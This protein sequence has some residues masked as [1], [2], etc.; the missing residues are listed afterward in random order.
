MGQR[1][2]PVGN[3]GRGLWKGLV[4]VPD[5]GVVRFELELLGSWEPQEQAAVEV[6]AALRGFAVAEYLVL[7]V[8]VV[9][10]GLPDVVVRDLV[11]A[12]LDSLVYAV[13]QFGNH[14]ER[15]VLAQLPSTPHCR[16]GSSNC[17]LLYLSCSESARS[18]IAK[19]HSSCPTAMHR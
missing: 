13:A 11:D 1:S 5:H 17:V 6:M 4:W 8:A 9:P 10:P 3:L 18:A 16:P 14:W 12:I 15:S 19:R 7:L 2:G